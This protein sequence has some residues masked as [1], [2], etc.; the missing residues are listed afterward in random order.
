[1]NRQQSRNQ[2]RAKLKALQEIRNLSPLALELVKE[3]SKQAQIIQMK[4]EEKMEL[5]SVMHCMY[6]TALY[7][8]YG[9]STTRLNR[10]IE[11]VNKQFIGVMDSSIDAKTEIVDW[12][13]GK[14][15]DFTL[16]AEAD[17]TGIAV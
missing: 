9:F 16:E 2:E 17:G 13:I 15:I 5:M 14:K 1:M 11:A 7:A 12:C 6:A 4:Q 3:I 10:T 8:D